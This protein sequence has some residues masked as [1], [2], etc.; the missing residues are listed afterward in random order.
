MMTWFVRVVVGLIVIGIV[1][2]IVGSLLPQNHTA[3]RTAVFHSRRKLS[4]LR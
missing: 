4:G 3:S 1:V 2:F